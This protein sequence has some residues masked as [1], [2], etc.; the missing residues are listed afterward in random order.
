MKKEFRKN[1][2]FT[3]Y[4]SLHYSKGLYILGFTCRPN[5]QKIRSNYKCGVIVINYKNDNIT[6]F[7]VVLEDGTATLEH[8]PTGV[9]LWVDEVCLVKCVRTLRSFNLASDNTLISVHK[10][11]GKYA[12]DVDVHEEERHARLKDF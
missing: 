1:G 10:D 5:T 11:L 7:S 12:D 3:D 8:V 6:D 2:A 9:Y 4:W